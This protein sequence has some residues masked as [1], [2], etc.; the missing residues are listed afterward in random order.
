MAKCIVCWDF[1]RRPK[2]TY[3]S[4]YAS[5]FP[6]GTVDLVQRSVALVRDEFTARRLKALA[7][8]YGASV[9]AFVLDAPLED[10]VEADTEASAFIARVHSQRLAQRG[11][12]ATQRKR[13]KGS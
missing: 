12:K 7:E 5:E 8:Y 13:R 11:R 6:P 3:Y 10:D 1:V 9:V 2:S 4:V